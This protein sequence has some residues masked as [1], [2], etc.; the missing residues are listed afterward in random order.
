MSVKLMA[1]RGVVLI[2][3]RDSCLIV[4]LNSVL[5]LRQGAQWVFV[6]HSNYRSNNIEVNLYLFSFLLFCV[7][8]TGPCSITQSGS[9]FAMESSLALNLGFSYLCLL[10]VEIACVCCHSYSFV[11]LFCIYRVHEK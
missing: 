8:E 10:R 9:E 4:I 7:L 2:M 1:H 3:E 6:T 11:E 5:F